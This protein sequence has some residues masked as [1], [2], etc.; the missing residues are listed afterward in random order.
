MNWSEDWEYPNDHIYAMEREK[1]IESS[2]QQWEEDQ[3]RK[4]AVIKVVKPIRK[5]EVI[6]R[7]KAIRRTHHKRL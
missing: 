5:D 3:K 4:P 7:S 2:W 6:N 1:D